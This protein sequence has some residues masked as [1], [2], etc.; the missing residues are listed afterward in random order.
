MRKL[1][2]VLHGKV[3]DTE[4]AIPIG[5]FSPDIACESP[6][7]FSETLYKKRSGELFLFGE[8]NTETKYAELAK[9]GWK[10]GSRIVPLSF[11]QARDWAAKYLDELPDIFRDVEDEETRETMSIS[12]PR[13]KAQKIRREAA[14]QGISISAVIAS[15]FED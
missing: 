1:K 15:K 12:L 2:K 4:K 11:S 14:E 5:E 7:F 13:S 10:S 3:Y 9:D 8:G 6:E